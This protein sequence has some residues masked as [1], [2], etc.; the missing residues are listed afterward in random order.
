MAV[1]TLIEARHGLSFFLFKIYKI[2]AVLRF[3]NN[4]KYEIL[5]SEVRGDRRR[6][7]AATWGR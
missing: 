4:S 5:D 6:G 1:S 3:E 7:G 2:D